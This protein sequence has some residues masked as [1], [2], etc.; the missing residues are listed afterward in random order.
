MNALAS[1]ACSHTPDEQLGIFRR[2][3]TVLASSVELDATL[4][5]TIRVCL[6][7]LGDFGFFDAIVEDG[8]RRTAAAHDDP[9]LEAMLAGTTWARQQHA[10]DLNLCALSSGEPAL[11]RD[12]DDAWYQ[13]IAVNEGHLAVLRQLG[14]TAM[15]TVPVRSGD[16]LIGSLTLFMAKSGRHYQEGDLVFAGELA[17]LA[18][19]VVNNARLLAR[20]HQ[21]NQTL[22]E[23][24]TA[25]ERRVQKRTSERD[26]IWSMSRDVLAVLSRSGE[27]ISI[28]PAFSALLGWPQGAAASLVDLVAPGQ[29]AALLMALSSGVPAQELEVQVRH[30]DGSLR[31]LAWTLVPEGELVYGVGRDVTGLRRQ[32]DEALQASEMRLQL[33]LEAGGMGGWQWDVRSDQC[34]W[35]PGMA[36]LHG[37]APT[38]QSSMKVYLELVVPED[39]AGLAQVVADALASGQDYHTEY[40]VAL[41]Q[42]GVRWLEARG[43]LHRDE[44]G[45]V[46]Q[47]AGI[48]VDITARKRTEQ[49]LRFVAQASAALASLE[50]IGATL[51]RVADLAV[52]HFADWCAVDLIDVDKHV[53]RVAV[54]HLDPDKLRLARQV[55]ERYRP[56]AGD[57]SAMWRILASGQTETVAEITEE[58][59]A[60]AARDDEHAAILRQLG[61]RSY[62]GVPLAV[63]GRNL[64]V[65]TFIVAEGERRYGPDDVALAEDIGRRA[66]VAIDNAKLYRALQKADQRKD[67]FLAML[68]HELR[69]PLAPIR[70]A[71]D[72]LALTRGDARLASISGVLSRQV[73]HMTGLVNDLLDVSR[74]TRGNIVLDNAPAD[75]GG[76]VM[77]AIEQARP[78]IDARNHQLHAHV[79][80]G[81]LTVMG[82]EKRLVQILVNLL[83]NAAKYT[84]PGGRIDVSA[85]AD[86]ADVLIE[87][88]D[89]GI[90]MSAELVTSAFELFAQ[91]ARASDRAQGG[92]GLG[93]ALVRRLVELHG[94]QVRAFSEGEGYGSR[95]AVRLP[96]LASAAVPASP[97]PLAAA[98]GPIRL[99]VLIVDDNI[100]AATVLG[101]FLEAAGHDVDVS[102]EPHAALRKVRRQAYDVCLLDIGLPGMDGH[103][104]ARRIRAECPAPAPVLIAVTGYGQS[105]DRSAALAAGFDHYLVKPVEA[106]NLTALLAQIAARAGQRCTE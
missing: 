43:K 9:E 92:L 94:G 17:A 67:E 85:R 89:N 104:L 72:L 38:Q 28:N 39:R 45:E 74:V 58:M 59:V 42:G 37:L 98:A 49:D 87:V 63:R 90:G 97:D 96:L 32:R 75:V 34:W 18:A 23:L 31:W 91:A 71:A 81:P 36:E 68:A 44:R 20:Q 21:L 26:R 27:L 30:R 16:S 47:V 22:A 84:L 52:P 70:A 25:L 69:N 102:Y 77:A 86:G 60:R 13:R 106:L 15:L 10:L 56:T 50:D 62:I 3:A 61:L 14:F 57:S 79:E 73:D 78:L 65:I 1:I 5:N 76:V 2:A 82:D 46:A 29:R 103:T 41:P 6:P 11:H 101:A 53:N 83:N 54:A 66:A 93:L 105:H 95:F 88:R 8:V 64:G 33:A 55:F 100:D 4:S 48:C 24:N 99:R 19:P 12:I 40:R 80:P 35:W 51:Q 7:S